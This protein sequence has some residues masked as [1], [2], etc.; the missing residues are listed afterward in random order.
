MRRS[1]RQSFLQS[2]KR[3]QLLKRE[4]LRAPHHQRQVHHLSKLLAGPSSPVL[5]ATER[6]KAA[7]TLLQ[8]LERHQPCL[9]AKMRKKRNGIFK[10]W[11]QC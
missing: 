8:R 11:M 1:A 2:N 6:V 3:P 7:P 9:A 10:R 4:V 5:K